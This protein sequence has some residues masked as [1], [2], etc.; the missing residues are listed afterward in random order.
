MADVTVQVIVTVPATLSVGQTAQAVARVVT[1]V[2]DSALDAKSVVWASSAPLVASVD[3]NGFVKALAAGSANI[4][5]T[6][7]TVFGTAPLVVSSPVAL[8]DAAAE[9]IVK[10]VAVGGSFTLRGPTLDFTVQVSA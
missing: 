6:I 8:I 10:S 5:A 1:D 9:A 4:K 3:A 2:N 7:G